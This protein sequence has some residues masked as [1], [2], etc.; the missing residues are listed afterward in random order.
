MWD[1]DDRQTS[2]AGKSAAA[3]AALREVITHS[4]P[5][6][7][8]AAAHLLLH[9]I[10]FHSQRQKTTAVPFFDDRRPQIE[11]L[12]S[13]APFSNHIFFDAL[14]QIIIRIQNCSINGFH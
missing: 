13:G 11:N 3:C 10:H 4:F 7:T 2:A 9:F 12:L 8:P 14:V 1:R 5:C 6:L